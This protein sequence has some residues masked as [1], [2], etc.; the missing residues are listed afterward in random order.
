MIGKN[1][2]PKR[3][4]LLTPRFVVW[5]SI[6]LSY[7]CVPGSGDH[8]L[9]GDPLKRP[10]AIASAFGKNFILRRCRDGTGI[11][12]TSLARKAS[13]PHRAVRQFY[14]KQRGREWAFRRARSF[15]M[16]KHQ[17]A[18]IA[19]PDPFRPERAE[20]GKAAKRFFAGLGRHAG[21]VSSIEM[22]TTLPVRNAETEIRR[23][24]PSSGL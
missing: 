2:A 12:G 4:E 8:R 6:Q 5:C 18:A 15:P 20:R 17:F 11:S 9:R 19:D 24:E 14:A 13:S 7:G 3:F 10:S 21:P 22:V 23:S 1:G 16:G